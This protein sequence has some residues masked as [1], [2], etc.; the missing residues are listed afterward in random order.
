MGKTVMFGVLRGLKEE[1]EEETRGCKTFFF[2]WHTQ[3]RENYRT[4]AQ[5]TPL[6]YG[7]R[8][9]LRW[10]VPVQLS[11]LELPSKGLTMLYRA[12]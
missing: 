11:T 7:V 5:V 9:V 12:V 1:E 6:R 3:S 10:L 8:D 4:L 2:L